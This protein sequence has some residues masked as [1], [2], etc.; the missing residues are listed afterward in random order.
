MN[1]YVERILCFIVEVL[2][3]IRNNVKFIRR[4]IFINHVHNAAGE[5]YHVLSDY[6]LKNKDNKK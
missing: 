5:K 6:N 1:L 4:M 3:K 2:V